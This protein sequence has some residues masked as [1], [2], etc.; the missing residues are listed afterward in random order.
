M[1][2]LVVVANINKNRDSRFIVLWKSNYVYD[3]YIVYIYTNQFFKYKIIL[4]RLMIII[5]D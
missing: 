3:E 1:T 2:N 5:M 4:Q